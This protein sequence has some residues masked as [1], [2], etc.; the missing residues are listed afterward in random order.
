MSPHRN[1]IKQCLSF[2]KRRIVDKHPQHWLII[3]LRGVR[4]TCKKRLD[5]E[6]FS[7][8]NASD[9]SYSV[10]GVAKAEIAMLTAG[11]TSMVHSLAHQ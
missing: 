11:R 5:T 2:V 7:D 1:S 9:V 3:L 6:V 10:M 8:L 4:K